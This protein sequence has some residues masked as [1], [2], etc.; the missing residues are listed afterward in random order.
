[1]DDAAGQGETLV[2]V[3]NGSSWRIQPS[4]NPPEASEGDGLNAVS[5]ASATSCSAV[6][7]YLSGGPAL[8]FAEYW[9]GS[10]WTVQSTRNA[11]GT[12]TYLQAV[13]CPSPGN[14]TAVGSTGGGG[15]LVETLKDGTWQAGSSPSP[16]SGAAFLGVSCTSATAC[17]AVGNYGTATAGVPLAERW[18]GHSWTVQPAPIAGT[19]AYQ[20]DYLTGVSCVAASWCMAG[21]SNETYYVPSTGSLSSVTER[22]S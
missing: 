21:G 4:P 1:M 12:D 10:S 19:G 3:W 8:A 22:Y 17:S 13:S 18:N 16:G 5:C 11:S 2:E 14:C 6:G 15:T 7:G 20:V 9:N